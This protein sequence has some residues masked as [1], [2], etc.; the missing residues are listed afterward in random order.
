[1]SACVPG[2]QRKIQS[3]PKNMRFVYQYFKKN[4]LS[5]KINLAMTDKDV[6]WDDFHGGAY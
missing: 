6:S 1:M 4:E 5:T 2:T 3:I